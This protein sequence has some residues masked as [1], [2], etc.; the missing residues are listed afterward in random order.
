MHSLGPGAAFIIVPEG[1][2]W[3]GSQG[4]P[5]WLLLRIVEAGTGSWEFIMPFT[6]RLCM[7]GI[8]PFGQFCFVLSEYD[9]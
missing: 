1:G 9:H 3:G 8:S 4:K 7:F 5:E 6:L 2:L